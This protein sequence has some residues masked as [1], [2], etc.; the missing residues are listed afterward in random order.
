MLTLPHTCRP[1][2]DYILLDHTKPVRLDT[3]GR[4]AGHE[5]AETIL[6]VD[7]SRAGLP[8]KLRLAVA[9]AHGVRGFEV[10]EARG[11]RESSS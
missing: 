6:G 9:P 8:G 2:T 10:L 5:A 7:I 4:N 11:R 1:V 3:F